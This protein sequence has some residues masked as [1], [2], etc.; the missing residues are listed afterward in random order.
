[1]SGVYLPSINLSLH[2]H[3]NYLGNVLLKFYFVIMTASFNFFYI[4]SF[5]Q[6]LIDQ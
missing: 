6:V 1:M 4:L 2:S 3:P 5:L